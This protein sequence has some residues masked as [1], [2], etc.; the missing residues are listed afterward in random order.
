MY[1]LF[2][3][4]SSINNEG[5]PDVCNN[6]DDMTETLSKMSQALKERFH[7]GSLI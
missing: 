7:I 4:F 5:C 2:E 6:M 1:K 3:I